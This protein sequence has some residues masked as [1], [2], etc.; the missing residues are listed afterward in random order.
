MVVVCGHNMGDIFRRNSFN[1]G[2]HVVQSPEAV[3]DAQDGDETADT[4]PQP[5][6]VLLTHQREAGLRLAMERLPAEQLRVLRLS[7]YEEQP[8]AQIARELG[9]PLGTVKSRV[10]LAVMHLRR[11]LDGLE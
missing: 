7:F 6:E 2:L 11:L 4:Q 9:I 8:H 1:L 10:R 3:A 5:D